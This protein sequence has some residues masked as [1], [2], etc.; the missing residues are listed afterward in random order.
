MKSTLGCAFLRDRSSFVNR[1][2]NTRRFDK[3]PLPHST[4]AFFEKYGIAI[5]V[6]SRCWLLGALSEL[7]AHHSRR[8]G[9]AHDPSCNPLHWTPRRT[10]QA[11]IQVLW[12]HEVS[13]TKSGTHIIEDLAHKIA[14][15]LGHQCTRS[16]SH[17]RGYT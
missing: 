15:D 7:L 13:V 3:R 10:A 14:H 6:N 4:L 11:W 8:Q 9:T 1:H 17:G 12:Y 5:C 2:T 16:A